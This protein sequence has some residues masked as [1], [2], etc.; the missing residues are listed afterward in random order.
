MKALHAFIKKE[1]LEQARSGRLLIL[2]IIFI[3]LGVMNPAVA[4]LTPWMLEMMADSLAGSG[5]IFTPVSVSALDA[6]TQFFKNI[7]I[8]LIAFVLLE[9]GVFTKEYQ[10]GTLLLSLTK[11]LARH[12]VVIAK[13]AVPA[14]LWTAACWLCAGITWGYSAYFWDN[15]IVQHLAF[16]VVCW[17]VFGLWAVALMTLFSVLCKSASGVLLGTGG[18]VLACTLFGMLPQIG[19]YLPTLLTDGNSLIYGIAEAESYSAPLLITCAAIAAYFAVSIPVFNR[20]L[21]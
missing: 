20:K 11:G 14:V 4:K 6:W 12:K 2:G 5:V 1:F 18:V 8:G 10:T 9:S 17:W 13:T 19:R 7:P 16:S 3:L 21:L 15:S